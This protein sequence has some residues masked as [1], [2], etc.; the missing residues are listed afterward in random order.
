M[1]CGSPSERECHT[2]V[3]ALRRFNVPSVWFRYDEGHVFDRPAAIADDIM[4]TTEWLDFWVRGIPYPDADR[5][6]EY[7]SWKSTPRW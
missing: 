7:D 2:F 6:K 3:A 5:A 1:Q 4:R